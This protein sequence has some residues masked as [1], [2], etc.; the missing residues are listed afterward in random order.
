MTTTSATYDPRVIQ[1]VAAT[2][3]FLGT[4]TG[5]SNTVAPGTATFTFTGG[6]GTEVCVMGGPVAFGHRDGRRVARRRGRSCR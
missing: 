5:I 2:G 1:D 6:T 3:W 4:R